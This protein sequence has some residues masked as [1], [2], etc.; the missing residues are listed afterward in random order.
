MT[1]PAE[2]LPAFLDDAELEQLTGRSRRQ[3]QIRWLRDHGFAFEVNARGAPVV[4]RR[5]AEQRLGVG[6]QAERPKPDVD[7]SH[8]P[9]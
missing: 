2:T 7:L 9:R 8:L 1:E 5:Y 3:A 4:A 6:Q